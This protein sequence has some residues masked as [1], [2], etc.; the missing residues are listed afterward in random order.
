MSTVE[1]NLY[2]PVFDGRAADWAHEAI[3]DMQRT[4][5]D[6]ALVEWEADLESAI[7]HSTPRYQLYPHVMTMDYDVVV[8]DGW[9]QTNNLP[10][11]PWLEGVGS[12]NAPVTRFPGYHAL[13]SA[14]ESV[15]GQVTDLCEPVVD[16]FVARV[17]HE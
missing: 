13:R 4:V 10:Y 1:V 14:F 8:N 17:N 6:H 3:R 11:G 16:D 9:G 15:S 7:R 12:R 5:A 2:G